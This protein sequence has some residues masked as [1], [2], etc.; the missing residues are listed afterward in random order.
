MCFFDINATYMHIK[1][2]LLKHL[3]TLLETTLSIIGKT[4]CVVC[5]KLMFCV[6]LECSQYVIPKYME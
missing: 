3:F 2:R 1:Y 5:Y 6:I 4:L